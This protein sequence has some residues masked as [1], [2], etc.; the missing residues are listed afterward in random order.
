MFSVLMTAHLLYAF[1]VRRTRAGVRLRRNG[2]LVAAVAGGIGLQAA[3]VTIPSLQDVFG[4]A[5]L[6]VR[7]WALVVL[8]G[9]LPVLMLRVPAL[10]ARYRR[11]IVTGRA[12]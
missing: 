1:V 4:T 2:W 8:L 11:R 9:V 3:V 10:I 5:P 6:T 7:E 12:V